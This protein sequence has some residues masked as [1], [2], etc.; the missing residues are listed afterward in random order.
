MGIQLNHIS[1]LT[2]ALLAAAVIAPAGHAQDTA[3]QT[4]PDALNDLGTTYS[5]DYFRNRGI[6]RQG[7]RIIGL[8]FPERALEWDANATSAAVR[9]ILLLQTT[10]DPTIRVPDLA[11][12]Y[13]SSLLTSPSSSVPYVGSEF[14]FETF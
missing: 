2:L 8:D 1:G 3:S 7:K 4:I 9:D 6:V 13:S 10:S 14:I 12:P 5:G 11:N